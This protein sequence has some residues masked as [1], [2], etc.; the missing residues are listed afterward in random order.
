MGKLSD[1]MVSDLDLRKLQCEDRTG[2]HLR[3]CYRF[4]KYFRRSPERMGEQEIRDFLLHLVR[5]RQASPALQKMF[6]AALKFL[7]RITLNRPGE[8]ERI[9]YPKIPKTL[10]DVL[11]RGEVV[12]ILDAVQSLE[13]K[14]I[15]ATA[16]APRLRITEA[17]SLKCRGDIDRDRMLI[18]VREGK[19]AQD[20]YV[21]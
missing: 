13:S 1:Q 21:M 6:V 11:S 16:Y 12:D 7:Y 2:V 9:P 8:V 14:A 20:R 10:P 18:H 19:R 3:T 17:S 4:A 15:I 5:E